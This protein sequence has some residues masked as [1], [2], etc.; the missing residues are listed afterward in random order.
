MGLSDDNKIAIIVGAILGALLLFI[1]HIT[2]KYVMYLFYPIYELPYEL[3]S[4]FVARG[5]EGEACAKELLGHGVKEI[6]DLK[7]LSSEI[8]ESIC[9]QLNTVESIKFKKAIH[10]LKTE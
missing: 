10:E 2:Y 4:W 9:G 6:G 3:A 7:L 5:I 1:R 8:L